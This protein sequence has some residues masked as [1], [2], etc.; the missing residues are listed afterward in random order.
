[1]IGIFLWIKF[2][3]SARR[4]SR[5]EASIY[6]HTNGKCNVLLLYISLLSAHR[7]AARGIELNNQIPSNR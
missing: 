7:K 2:K 1:M 4:L 3:G 6:K 5:I